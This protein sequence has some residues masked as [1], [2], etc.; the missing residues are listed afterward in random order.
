MLTSQV[1]SCMHDRRLTPD[2]EGGCGDL[3]DGGASDGI[4]MVIGDDKGT[5]VVSMC[6]SFEMSL[7]NNCQKVAMVTFYQSEIFK[8]W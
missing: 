1:Q 3:D 2:L 7:L 6:C 5:I 8:T 4:M